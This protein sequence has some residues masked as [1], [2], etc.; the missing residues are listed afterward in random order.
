YRDLAGFDFASSEVN[1]PLVRQLH[2]C[3]FIEPSDNV[4]LV[5]GPGTGKT[6]I[7]TALGVQAIEYHKK[8]VRFFSTVEMVNALEQEKAQGKAG[9]IA[10]RLVHADLV[11]LDELGY[12]P[13][14]TSGGALLFHLLSKLYERTS[15]A[16]TTNLSF[17]EW[18]AVFGDAKMTT[19]LLDRLT[20]HCHIL[21]TGNDS[22]KFKNRSVQKA[23]NR[24]NPPLTLS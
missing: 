6:H 23:Q 5:G 24:K 11:I 10:S 7:A 17:S 2:R 1:E 12:L 13:F 3:D 8:R 19:A 9:Q 4:V 14:S 21:E 15:V 16:I 20:H 22:F 18:S